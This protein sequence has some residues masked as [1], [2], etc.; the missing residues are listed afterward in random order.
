MKIPFNV[1]AAAVAFVLFG[2]TSGKETMVTTTDQTQKRT[3]TQ[4]ELK[5]TGATEPGTA[6][7]KADAAVQTSSHP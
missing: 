4:E 1:P 7:E 6:L 3:H 5:K 2:C